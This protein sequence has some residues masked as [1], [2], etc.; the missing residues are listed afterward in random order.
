MGEI[1]KKAGRRQVIILFFIFLGQGIA[2][3]LYKITCRRAVFSGLSGVSEYN[4]QNQMSPFFKIATHLKHKSCQENSKKQVAPCTIYNNG[5]TQAKQRLRS[6][7]ISGEMFLQ[8]FPV[9]Y[10]V[11]LQRCG[12]FKRSDS[13]K[14]I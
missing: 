1:I 7:V 11:F 12:T 8:V 9:P 14:N 13:K 4:R 3:A 5:R 10:S 2:S 6:S